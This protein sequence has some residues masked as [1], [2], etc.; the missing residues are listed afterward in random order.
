MSSTSSRTLS[1]GILRELIFDPPAVI[2]LEVDTNGI[3]EEPLL[4]FVSVCVA[5]SMVEASRDPVAVGLTS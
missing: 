5:L 3:C 2:R 4:V 1:L